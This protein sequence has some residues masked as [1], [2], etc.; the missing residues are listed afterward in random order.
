MGVYDR[1]VIGG[2]KSI[3]KSFQSPYRGAYEYK[4][5]AVRVLMGVFE[6]GSIGAQYAFNRNKSYYLFSLDPPPRLCNLLHKTR[7]TSR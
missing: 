6:N 3:P 5:A 4:H 2:Y 1:H 7:S